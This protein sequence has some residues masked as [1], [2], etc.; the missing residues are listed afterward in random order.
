[1]NIDELFV[2]FVEIIDNEIE[3][4]LMIRYRLVVLGAMADVDQ[5]KCIP[6]AVNETEKACESLRLVEL[7]RG[8]VTAELTELLGLDSSARIDEIAECAKEAW[9]EILM[10]RRVSLIATV[11]DIQEVADRVSEKMGSRSALAAEALAFLRT[12]GGSTYGRS[13][14]RGG[15]LVEGAI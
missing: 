13:V 3:L 12:D 4:L 14:P 15:V 1:M 5:G 10:E 8:S 9:G 7:M 11:K 6:V 2:Q